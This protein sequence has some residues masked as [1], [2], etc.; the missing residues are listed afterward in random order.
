MIIA[1]VLAALA[2]IFGAPQNDLLIL[3]I[4]KPV[5][6]IVIDQ[7]RKAEILG[8]IKSIKKMKKAYGK[9]TKVFTK[10]LKQ[11]A[12]DQKTDRET[13]DAFYDSV[14]AYEV[15][16]SDEFI[17]HRIRIQ[18]NL[19]QE[20]WDEIISASS[21]AIKK[22]DK[23][24]QKALSK[25]KKGLDKMRSKVLKHIDGQERMETAG[26]YMEAFSSS[27]YDRAVEILKYD[28]FE[29]EILLNKNASEDDLRS[30]VEGTNEHWMAIFE[31]FSKLHAE[32]GSLATEAEWKSLSRELKKII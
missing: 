23:S 1:A 16:A 6:Q 11:L 18:D 22:D 14:V 12:I 8:E 20:E 4:K 24:S 25:L 19:T 26:R 15:L 31:T 13:F 3:K 29:E 30:V 10:Q 21:K 27:L 2:I 9:K 28:P 5:K 32:L 17:Q 7:D